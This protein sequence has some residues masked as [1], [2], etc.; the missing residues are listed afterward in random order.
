MHA[1]SP[2]AVSSGVVA[3][4]RKERGGRGE[5][6]SNRGSV[7]SRRERL[8]RPE[9]S[10]TRKNTSTVTFD[11]PGKDRRGEENHRGDIGSKEL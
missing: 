7:D 2:I 6:C 8:N 10:A 5:C 3:G 4:R 9:R 11:L 1:S